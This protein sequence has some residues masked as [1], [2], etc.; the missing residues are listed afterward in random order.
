MPNRPE[1]SSGRTPKEKV[2]KLFIKC[3]TVF[4]ALPIWMDPDNDPIRRNH[5][6]PFG[7]TT[8]QATWVR[9]YLLLPWLC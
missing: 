4:S 7:L 1:C 8:R 9:L 3:A 6:L 5:P 2:A